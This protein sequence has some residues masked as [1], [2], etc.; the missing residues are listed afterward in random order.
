MSKRFLIIGAVVAAVI[1]LPIAWWLA[2][3]LFIQ[4]TVEEAFPFDVPTTAEIEEM[5]PDEAQDKVMDIMTEMETMDM[6]EVSDE[7]IATVEESLMEMAEVMP[8]KE[9]EE[10]MPTPVATDV[11]EWVVAAQGSFRDGGSSYQGSGTATI[12][13]QGDERILRFEDFEV[14]NGPDLHVLLV[15]NIDGERGELGNYVD[16][17][18]LKGNVGNQNYEIPADV[19]LDDYAGI[20][21]Y[22]QPFHV[23]FSTAP[24]Q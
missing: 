4:N 7:E 11:P 14:T 3:P 18:S 9:M 19:N 24:F 8:E 6:D 20:M 5:S 23:V 13:Q 17:G 12:F 21:I 22:C 15:Q 2:S 1:I 10:P 16:L